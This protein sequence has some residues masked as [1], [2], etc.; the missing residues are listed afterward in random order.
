M[1]HH[2]PLRFD[3]RKFAALASRVDD[4]LDDRKGCPW[5]KA[6]S[7]AKLAKMLVG[8]AEELLEA[9]RRPEDAAEEA[10]DCF[11][12]LFL[13]LAKL[14]DRRGL[15]PNRALD[16]ICEKIVRRHTWIYGEDKAL[17]SGQV[18]KLWRRNKA[19]ER[20]EKAKKGTKAQ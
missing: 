15:S 6:Q 16:S 9:I 3:P 14:Q 19:I 7:A 13:I 8:E 10:G 4:L 11:M 1:A 20:R 17:N 18:M 12:L 2:V 5:D